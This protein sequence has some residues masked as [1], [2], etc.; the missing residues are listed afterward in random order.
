MNT[1]ESLLETQKVM[2]DSDITTAIECLLS[3]KSGVTA[4]LVD[5]ATAQG[6]V[7]LSGHT[8]NLLSRERAEQIAEAVRGVRSVRNKIAIPA[9]EL[10]DST[11]RRDVEETL[12]QDA[13]ASQYE[14]SYTAREGVVMV[15]GEVPSWSEKRVVLLDTSTI[16]KRL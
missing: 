5:V 9:T 1:F 10:P 14:I 12:L 15:L 4:H 11:L 7:T 3:C 8:D 13:V 2:A 6:I 16:E